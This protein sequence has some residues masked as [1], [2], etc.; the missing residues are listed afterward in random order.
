MTSVSLTGE[1]VTTTCG[2]LARG[3]GRLLSRAGW[4][5]PRAVDSTEKRLKASLHTRPR[6]GGGEL[7]GLLEAIVPGALMALGNDI[8]VF[9]GR[10]RCIEPDTRRKG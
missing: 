3:G 9:S 4:C 2:S 10:C 7:C 1:V 6:D 8:V 5:P